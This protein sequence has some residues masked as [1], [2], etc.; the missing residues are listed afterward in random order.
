MSTAP[1]LN[2]A[3]RVL[4]VEDELLYGDLLS[5]QL[6]A[7]GFEPLGPVATAAQAQTMFEALRPDLVLLDVGLRGPMDGIALAAAL[8]ARQPV[9][10]IFV[11]AAT[12][13][14][15]FERARAVGPA[16]FI[17][18]PFDATTLQNAVE[19][20]LH[21]F[22]APS[23]NHPAAPVPADGPA[24]LVRDA[25]FL[26]ERE[27]LVKVPH[28]AVLYVEAD[29]RHCVLVLANGRRHALRRPLRELADELAV[30]DFLQIHRSFVLNLRH[31][32]SLNPA[33][34]TVQVAGR[35]LPLGRSYRDELL[36]RLHLLEGRE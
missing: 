9:P 33:E 31:L 27:G 2:P 25:F 28:G 5:E 26:K 18:K 11:T 24:A 8:L 15:T 7:L 21:N 30:H 4:I 22:A 12:D 36:R 19:L 10:L 20:A 6:E 17:A 16:A 3:I 29:D 32:D 34:F 35:T 14:A 23:A 13:R 1:A